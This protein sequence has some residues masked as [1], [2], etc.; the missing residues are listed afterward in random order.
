MYLYINTVDG[1]KIILALID[2]HGQILKFK[3]INAKYKQSEKLLVNIEKI[4]DGK[5][6]K[7]K[8]VIVIK[9]PGSFTALRIGLTTANVLAWSLKLPI[10]GL[11]SIGEIDEKKLIFKGYNKIKKIKSFKALMPEYGREPN[12]TI[13][14]V[15]KSTK[16]SKGSVN[17]KNS[18][19]DKI[20][21]SS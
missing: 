18:K 19:R 7:I 17:S 9:G 16:T 20:S 11:M 3:K 15:N 21:E 8:G 12:I 5:L 2:K 1:K 14:K 13:S 6:K 10:V 4:T